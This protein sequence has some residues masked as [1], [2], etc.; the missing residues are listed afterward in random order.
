MAAVLGWSREGVVVEETGEEE[1]EEASLHSR[2]LQAGEVVV[3]EVQMASCLAG[4]R[5]WAK[6][7]TAWE[8]SKWWV[9]L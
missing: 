4:M 2:R 6:C 5:R 3:E 9:T 8:D 1:E 7:V